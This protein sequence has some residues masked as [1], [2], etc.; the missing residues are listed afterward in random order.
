MQKKTPRYENGIVYWRCSLCGEWK[1]EDDYYKNNRTAN[2]LTVQCK[3]CHIQTAIKTRNPENKKRINREYMRRA[4]KTD[5][6]KYR[7]RER[8]ASRKRPK[9]E[10]TKARKILNNAV[11]SG[12][13]IRPANCSECGKLRKITAHHDD[14]SKPLEVRWLCYECHGSK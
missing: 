8:I 14:Y 9:N 2:K 1:L 6:K 4:R 10:K 11:R 5:P 13:I 7:R 3:Q 12:K